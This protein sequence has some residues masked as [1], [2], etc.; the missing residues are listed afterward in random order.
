MF[1]SPTGRLLAQNSRMRGR[2]CSLLFAQPFV[3]LDKLAAEMSPRRT[4]PSPVS[5]RLIV[6]PDGSLVSAM[7]PVPH[8]P[9]PLPSSFCSSPLLPF[10]SS[11]LPTP[12]H[13]SPP[14][15]VP[16]SASLLPPR[17][18]HLPSRSPRLS[19]SCV[20]AVAHCGSE[21]AEEQRPGRRRRRRQRHASNAVA[22]RGLRR[23][24]GDRGRGNG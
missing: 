19:L 4:P 11:P 3:Q 22:A 15:R 16:A 9:L 23:K 21:R 20:L 14:P 10:P 7:P 13:P 17:V 2:H 18:P 8:P 1:N 12:T 5:P 24:D 6:V